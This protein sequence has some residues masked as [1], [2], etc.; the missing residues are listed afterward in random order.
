MSRFAVITFRLECTRKCCFLKDIHFVAI[1]DGVDSEK[2]DNDFHP[3]AEPF[4]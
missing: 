1:N 2:G 3:A 4:Q